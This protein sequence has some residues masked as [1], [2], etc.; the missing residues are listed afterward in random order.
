MA[1][2]EE[3]ARSASKAASRAFQGLEKSVAEVH[4]S[5]AIAGRANSTRFLVLVAEAC[6]ENFS[7]VCEAAAVRIAE[8]EG[9]AASGYADSLTEILGPLADRVVEVYKRAA[10]RMFANSK[11]AQET[12]QEL[13]EFLTGEIED[14]RGD[15]KLGIAGGLNVKKQQS[16]S[17]DIKGGANQLAVNSP[18][19]NQTVGGNMVGS[20]GLDSKA[21]VDVL[22]LIRREVEAS[23]L[24]I[25]HK[26]E[27]E[28]AVVL[29]EGEAKSDQP[30]EGRIK[31]ALSTIAKKGGEV[32]LKIG[33]ELVEHYLRSKGLIA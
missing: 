32:G 8:I 31:R 30:N 17:I 5:A 6:K 24:T 12:E 15:L 7:N 29:A 9:E 22:E 23:P 19:S 16:L 11:F 4:R 14:V 28:D 27:I 25:E 13:K 26:E 3:V 1:D 18:G 20:A 33:G 21:L 10:G 2:P